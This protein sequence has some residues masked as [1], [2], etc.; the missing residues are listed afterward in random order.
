MHVM[1]PEGVSACRSKNVKGEWV[2]KVYD[3]VIDCSL[4]GRNSDNE[5]D[6]RF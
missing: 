3:Y 5:G 1:A 2:E 6:R 4:K